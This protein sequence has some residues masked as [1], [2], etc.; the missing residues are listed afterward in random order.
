MRSLHVITSDSRRGAETFAIDLA[1]ALQRRGQEAEVRALVG[2]GN[3]TRHPVAT[4]GHRQRSPSMLR[5]IRREA[6]DFDVVVAHGSSTLETCAV[7]LLGS[8]RPF[9]YRSIGDP[10]FWVQAPHRR[11]GVNLLLRRAERVVALWSDAAIVLAS[12]YRLDP[13]RIDTIPNGVDEKRFSVPDEEVR[14][15]ARR[16]YGVDDSR[17]CLAFVGALSPEKHVMTALRVVEALAD[18]NLII[19]GHGPLEADMRATAAR[20][21][22][23]RV[24]FLGQVADTRSVYAAAD[25]LLLPS[26]SEGMPAVVIEA[27]LMGCATVAT[28]VGALPDMISDDATGFLASAG[29]PSS[30]AATVARA[31]PRARSVGRSAARVFAGTY[32]IDP[33]A[34]AWARTLD[35]AVRS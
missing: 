27:A 4:L 13:G 21:A 23:G 1:E 9:V 19:A 29:A 22:P 11:V 5:T 35:L 25:L 34:E 20:I 16:R 24:H 26:L 33:I 15:D 31:I 7:A 14:R 8:D 17:A 6:A 32:A 18:T 28:S 3:P 30:F 2:S 10:R 12:Q